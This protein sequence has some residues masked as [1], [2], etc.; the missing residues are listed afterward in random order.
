MNRA[1]ALA[2]L[3]SAGLASISH[4]LD[5]LMKDSIRITAHSIDDAVLAIGA[6]KLGGE[7]D[8]P[9]GTQ[10]PTGKGQ[11][12]SFVAQIRLPD[13]APLDPQ[14]ALP[15]GGMLWFFYD[16]RQE[17][18][19]ADPA[20]R[21]GW[22]VLYGAGDLGTLVR[23]SAPAMLPSSARFKP[24]AA[25]FTGEVTLPQQPELDIPTLAWTSQ[26]KEAYEN[27]LGAF[28]SPSDRALPHHRMLGNPDT[29]QDDMRL[30]CQ[31]AANGV[32]DASAPAAA[33]L[34]AGAKNWRL[35][36]QVD[37]DDTLGMRWADA[38]MLYFW[39]ENDALAA[40]RFDNVW[41]VLQSD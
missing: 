6:S 36:L 31:L 35:L 23:R 8:M 27:A 3:S 15:L 37:S 19:G 28:P 14:L 9:V 11:P 22:A 33:A 17:T 41:V 20:D 2:A 29:I 38:G 39:I 4:D 30:E 21:G 7:P 1:D 24:C 34:K 13:V 25:T 32:S 16:A 18:Y 10:W 40:H 12:L 5:A 26:Q